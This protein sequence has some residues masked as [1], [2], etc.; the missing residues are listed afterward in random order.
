M[1]DIIKLLGIVCYWVFTLVGGMTVATVGI[2]YIIDGKFNVVNPTAFGL[3][4]LFVGFACSFTTVF[5]GILEQRGFLNK[6]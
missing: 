4:L 6:K 5:L 1:M 2:I 3:L